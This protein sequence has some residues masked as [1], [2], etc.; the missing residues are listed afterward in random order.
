MNALQTA[1]I[2]W[3]IVFVLL[4]KWWIL[5][6]LLWFIRKFLSQPWN[7]VELQLKREEYVPIYFIHTLVAAASVA[8]TI[9]Y[10][11]H[12]RIYKSIREEIRMGRWLNGHHPIDTSKWNGSLSLMAEQIYLPGTTLCPHRVRWF[13][14]QYNFSGPD[15]MEEDEDIYNGLLDGWTIGGDKHAASLSD[16][17]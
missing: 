10:S 11:V 3:L 2:E 12:K 16:P 8:K 7:S 13:R 4:F 14:K 9:R 15:W 6:P 17:T 5:W 1:I